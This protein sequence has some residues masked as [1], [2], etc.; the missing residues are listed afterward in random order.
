MMEETKTSASGTIN[1][2]ETKCK[3]GIVMENCP[4]CANKGTEECKQCSQSSDEPTCTWEMAL[5]KC[6]LLQ[7]KGVEECKQCSKLSI[8]PEF[9]E[10]RCPKGIVYKN[11]AGYAAGECNRCLH[12]PCGQIPSRR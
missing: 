10:H 5:S 1:P 12:S 7:K 9:T 8:R 2:E 3:W 6:P 4:I 11:C